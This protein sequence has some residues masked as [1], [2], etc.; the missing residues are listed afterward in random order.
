MHQSMPDMLSKEEQNWEEEWMVILNSKG[1]YILSKMQAIILKQAIATGNRGTIMFETFAIPIP[2]MV[3]FYR[4]R[5]FLKDA[6]QLMERAKEA[7]YIPMD[8]K[9]FAKLKKEVYKK[10]GNIPKKEKK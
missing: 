1:K 7:E 4:V 3:E 6:V 9:K 8:P 10:I 2:F 5:R